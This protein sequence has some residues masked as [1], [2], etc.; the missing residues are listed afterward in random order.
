MKENEIRCPECNSELK[1][2]GHCGY[3]NNNKC[4]MTIVWMDNII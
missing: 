2:T 1:V 4:S 3:C